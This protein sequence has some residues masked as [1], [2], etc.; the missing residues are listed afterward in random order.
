M[1]N[2]IL[3][4]ITCAFIF[5]ILI[6]VCVLCISL[7]ENMSLTIKTFK[8]DNFDSEAINYMHQQYVKYLTYS[9][10]SALGTLAII[11]LA[12]LIFVK[13]FPKIHKNKSNSNS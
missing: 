10:F 6:A 1:K 12:T 7:A 11:L 8:N 3:K 9:I 13:E 4:L 5:A 2:T